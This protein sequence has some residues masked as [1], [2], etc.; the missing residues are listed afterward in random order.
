MKTASAGNDLWH[1][2]HCAISCLVLTI[3]TIAAL[4]RGTDNSDQQPI[5]L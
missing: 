3:F 1:A 2:S 4:R 5:M